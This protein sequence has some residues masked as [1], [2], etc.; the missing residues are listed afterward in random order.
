M[1][2]IFNN[3]N[4]ALYPTE[5]A[6]ILHGWGAVPPYDA[7]RIPN[8]SDTVGAG[9][10]LAKMGTSIP[11]PFAR[12]F[13]FKTAFEMVNASTQGANDSSAYGKLVSECLD[14]LEFIY[15]N[16]NDITV[17]AWNVDN[18]LQALKDSPNTKHQHL[19]SSLENFA[20]SLGVADIYLIYYNNILI[21]GTSP[22]TLVYTSP[23]WQRLKNV[24]EARG[25]EGNL[26][27]PDYSLAHVTP[28][29]LHQRS[30]EFQIML[31]RYYV[32][33]RNVNN[34]TN[35]AFFQY[36]YRNQD[37]FSSVAKNEFNSITGINAYSVSKF[38]SDYGCVGDGVREIDILGMGGNNTL[39]LPKKFNTV[40]V[41]GPIG[42]DLISDDY[43]IIP[44]VNRHGNDSAPL[45]LTKSG[46]TGAI[47]LSGN[48]LPRDIQIT[49]D[50]NVSL[51]D[52]ILPGGM[53]IHYPYLTVGDFLE[54]RLVKTSYKVDAEHFH[55]F[56]I[57]S[58]N[59]DNGYLLPL[60]KTFFEYFSPEDF[61]KV[62]NPYLKIS[63][64][65][66]D[67]NTVEVCLQIPVMCQSHP[68]IE[69]K[70]TYGKEDIETLGSDPNIFTLA[71]FPSYKI[72]TNNVP[73]RYSVMFHDTNKK[74]GVSFHAF[75][76]NTIERVESDTPNWRPTTGSCYYSLDRAFDLIQL[77][78]NGARALVL[79]RFKPVNVAAHGSNTAVGIDF[80]TT[81][82]YICLSTTGGAS[83]QSLEISK[84]DMQVMVLNKVDLSKG[85]FGEK[86]MD[87]MFNMPSFTQALDREFV[88]LLLGRQSDVSYPYRTVTCETDTFEIE[89]R[90]HLFAD[91]SIG[92]NFMKEIAQ[93]EKERYNTNIKWDIETGSDNL[94]IKANRV[95]KYCEQTAWMVKNKLMLMQNPSDVLNL[96][97]TFPHTMSRT[98]KNQIE[99]F[100]KEAFNRHMGPGKTTV[101]RVTESI[102]PYYSMIANGARFTENALNID[103]GGG[104]TDM[105]FADV[106]NKKFL[107]S[108]SLFAGN[109]IWG[110]GKQL[111]QM[112]QKDNGFVKDFESK[113]DT[114]LLVGNERKEGYLRY[115][116]IVDSSSDLMTYVFRYD[117]EFRYVD[118]IKKSNDKLMPIL[119]VHLGALL[120]HV[121]QVVKETGITMP[122]TIMFS[123]MGAQYIRIIND[124]PDDIKIIVDKLLSTFLGQEMPRG[125]KV[126]FQENA[127]EV[128]AQGAML[129]GHSKLSSIKDYKQEP[130]CVYGV[131]TKGKA[132]SYEDAPGY[133]EKVSDAFDQFIKN[134]VENDTIRKFFKKEFEIELTDDLAETLRDA[135]SNSFDLMAQE[136]DGDN[137][138]EETMFFWP[139]KNGLYEAS[140]Q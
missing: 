12:I 33:F 70:K 87:S 54:D 55:T 100:W 48:P 29:P 46:I 119:C 85:N 136:K 25:L 71:V 27:F 93:L 53:N 56:G 72:V 82:T 129:V 51:N 106:K 50:R 102:A 49:D 101:I 120:Y 89:A 61:G 108:S 66:I 94:S 126:Q 3:T 40:N 104:T 8:I 112:T 38:I 124:N 58:S 118:Y 26:L 74:L 1:T 84:N 128:T 36:L 68:W 35:T 62:E 45:V 64:S 57:D 67:N 41:V 110:D 97:L 76:N 103:I 44:T 2:K 16:G 96:Y 18:E 73:N 9:I 59:K 127:K 32:A 23:N 134:F 95:S 140:K 139:L 22:F 92:F 113:L 88:P 133:K 135:A 17:R 19:A 90:P 132:I 80:G 21:G 75:G 116:E 138:V 63:L 47:Y 81:N 83:P 98:T 86:Y 42:T 114:E 5:A 7:N 123:G 60:T 10:A 43:K 14:F 37:V 125:F 91:I 99:N 131:D 79:P 105:L 130:L 15:L 31:T 122:T 39:F 109:D 121:A 77:E 117:N 111:V 115:R 78:W 11:T 30:Q 4:K 20:R 24:T 137:E 65:E 6:R 34:L 28:T 13:L 107:Y 52:R 69:L